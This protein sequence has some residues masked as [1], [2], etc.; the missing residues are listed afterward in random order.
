[1]LPASYLFT[2]RI[3]I[4]T[5][6]GK[7]QYRVTCSVLGEVIEVKAPFLQLP[8]KA[9][10]LTAGNE[11]ETYT[12]HLQA[13]QQLLR[14]QIPLAVLGFWPDDQF[15]S[16]LAD[17]QQQETTM[18]D[19]LPEN[20]VRL[21]NDP[22]VKE[23][24]EKLKAYIAS[25][26]SGQYWEHLTSLLFLTD[27]STDKELHQLTTHPWQLP[28]PILADLWPI[29]TDR[30]RLRQLLTQARHYPSEGTKKWLMDWLPREH[31]TFFR[32]LILE[33]LIP[34]Q[35]EKLYQLLIDHYYEPREMG[36]FES[37]SLIQNLSAYPTEEVREI[38]WKALT[39]KNFFAAKAA[40]SVLKNQAV[41]ERM[42]AL[43]L[44]EAMYD[45][46]FT[47]RLGSLF[48]RYQA[49]EKDE[50]LLLAG[51]YL[52]R[53]VQAVKVNRSA[54]FQ[55][56]LGALLNRCWTPAVPNLLIELLHH[57]QPMV[58]RLALDQISVIVLQFPRRAFPLRVDTVRRI[59]QL[60]L[61]ATMAVQIEAIQTIRLLT[62]R[63]GQKE[64]I[65]SLLNVPKRRTLLP[66]IMPALLALHEKG[67][68]EVAVINFCFPLSKH[69]DWNVRK[70]AVLL[71]QYYYSSPVEK[72]LKEM[73]SDPHEAVRNALAKGWR[74]D[75]EVLRIIK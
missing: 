18:T 2:S 13:H 67:Y 62:P 14:Y 30:T 6:A 40:H 65:R 9:Q 42:I 28:A 41:D 50:C 8:K 37:E 38:A 24:Y 35:D 63:F 11:L 23:V 48:S 74:K 15:D 34:Y 46:Y 64:W 1:M 54:R 19:P 69:D 7:F 32:A 44:R 45:K 58:R 39:G 22:W 26:E 55:V 4:N 25:R 52:K 27:H 71:L 10:Q 57:P 5:V 60:T 29:I 12:A 72:H 66:Y 17:L 73:E 61:D 47:D 16:L 53:A 21:I 36:Q 59:F 43:K 68:Q 75:D 33:A 3:K 56:N 31:S 49:L 70:D 20:F 51:D